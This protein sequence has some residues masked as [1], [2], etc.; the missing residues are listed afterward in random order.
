[1]PP[2]RRVAFVSLALLAWGPGLARAQPEPP[3]AR[4]VDVVFVGD[5]IEA[6]GLAPVLEE[7]LARIDVELR[8][9]PIEAVL[10]PR[11]VLTPRPDA[12]PALARIWIELADDRTTIYLVDDAWERIL[13]RHVPTGG[14]LD[15]VSREQVAHIVHAAVDA[16]LAGARIGLTRVEASERLGVAPE[17]PPEPTESPEPPE[18]PPEPA[19]GADVVLAYTPQLFADGP[20]VRHAVSVL[21][22]L[23]V[24]RRSPRLA[25]TAGIDVW[26]SSDHEGAGLGLELSTVTLRAEAA[27]EVRV[28]EGTHV[29][30]GGGLALD[31]TTAQTRRLAGSMVE[32]AESFTEAGP[33][34]CLRL[35][36]QQRLWEW[37]SLSGG[38]LVDVDLL[39]TRYV[40]EGNERDDAV[41][42]PWLVRPALWLGVG[43]RFR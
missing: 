21:G 6:S 28:I 7:L 34:V 19:L 8:Q 18:P 17:P 14:A 36:V 35:A 39:D 5:A 30:V 12:P 42:D 20:A 15:E 40:V 2:A 13:V 25:L 10:D 9:G 1:M 3:R 37:I 23:L 26:P 41:V 43:G 22:S 31:V 16:L 29:R 11:A 24:G 27:V 4:A 33:L 32:V 38:L